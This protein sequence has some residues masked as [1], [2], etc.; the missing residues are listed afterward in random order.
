MKQWKCSMCAHCP[1]IMSGGGGGMV[2]VCQRGLPHSRDVVLIS[3][4]GSL[5]MTNS[6][7]P[8]PP[9]G[10]GRRAAAGAADTDC[11]AS[12]SATRLLRASIVA[13]ASLVSLAVS[14]AASLAVSLSVSLAVSLAPVCFG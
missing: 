14:L 3:P 1:A 2:T 7:A 5:D 12:S 4:G 13:L 10:G 9:A 11:I 8:I 6:R